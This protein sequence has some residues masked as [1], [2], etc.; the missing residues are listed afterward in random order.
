MKESS[1]SNKINALSGHTQTNIRFG[2]INIADM[3]LKLD[4]FVSEYKIIHKIKENTE[5]CICLIENKSH[6]KFILKV[7]LNNVVS[8]NEIEIYTRVQKN[9]HPNLMTIHKILSSKKFFI[10]IYNFIDGYDFNSTKFYPLYS[11]S[12]NTIF[13]DILSGL[14]FLH[15]LGISHHD[16]KPDNIIIVNNSSNA[17]NTSI[18]IDIDTDIDNRSITSTDKFTPIIIDF[19]NAI[20]NFNELEF[21]DQQ[22]DTIKSDTIKSDTMSDN[23]FQMNIKKDIVRTALMFYFYIFHKSVNIVDVMN[24][25]LN[26]ALIEDYQ[27]EHKN[28]IDVIDWILNYD[29]SMCPSPK[30]IIEKLNQ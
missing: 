11:N 22:S 12:I 2:Y 16:I 8:K 15:D 21:D 7:K 20:A 26:D 27:G 28:I 18:D 24:H 1:K 25:N 10:V 13:K 17:T 19:D 5:K 23:M 4:L 3:V 14:S 29:I 30:Q 9:P 6:Q